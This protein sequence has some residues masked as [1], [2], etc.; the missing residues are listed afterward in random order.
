MLLAQG[1]GRLI[2][3]SSDRGVVAVLDPRLSTQ[4]AYRGDLL[5]ALP[6][7]RRTRHFDEVASFLATITAD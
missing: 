1:C 5:D 6:P 7:F 4:A 2:R 3:S